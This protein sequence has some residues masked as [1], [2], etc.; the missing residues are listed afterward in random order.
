MY[1]VASILF[2]RATWKFVSLQEIVRRR[3]FIPEVKDGNVRSPCE[4][5]HCENVFETIYTCIKSI[6]KIHIQQILYLL[7][8]TMSETLYFIK[9]NIFSY[10]YISLINFF[11]CNSFTWRDILISILVY[12]INK[13]YLLLQTVY[14]PYMDAS[15]T[16]QEFT[17][18]YTLYKYICIVGLNAT[19]FLLSSLFLPPLFPF[20]DKSTEFS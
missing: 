5:F 6:C 14:T 1:P 2:I 15:L 8:I 13:Y 7:N 18:V 16:F 19:F 9:L 12:T 20:L 10:R 3:T 4:R 17:Y 11:H